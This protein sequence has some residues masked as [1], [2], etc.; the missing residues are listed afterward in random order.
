M[1]A[2]GDAKV[3][4]SPVD[5][6]VQRAVHVGP[7]RRQPAQD[8]H[9]DE[10]HENERPRDRKQPA[11]R[12]RPV[13]AQ[14]R[15]LGGF[16]DRQALV[17]IEREPGI[18]IL[19]VELRRSKVRMSVTPRSPRSAARRAARSLWRRCTMRRGR[20]VGQHQAQHLLELLHV[21]GVVLAMIEQE[22]HGARP[23]GRGAAAPGGPTPAP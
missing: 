19:G 13:A 15:R 14:Q 21:L 16:V 12:N 10:E 3:L 4:Q 18:G 8:L 9:D 20:L 2:S 5:H 7:A 23:A 17:E 6:P 22:L 11:P 1:L